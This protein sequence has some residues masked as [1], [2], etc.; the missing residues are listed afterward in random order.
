MGRQSAAAPA[1][2]ESRFNNS[3]YGRVWKFYTDKGGGDEGARPRADAAR[4]GRP[5]ADPDA[6][7]RRS[8][9][10][11]CGPGHGPLLRGA[12]EFFSFEGNLYS[13][14]DGDHRKSTEE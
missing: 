13:T 5:R 1:D 3:I 12:V 11:P 8:A 14:I 2:A 6:R 4:G 7:A 9:H 10:R